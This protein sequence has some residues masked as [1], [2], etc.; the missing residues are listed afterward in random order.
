MATTQIEARG[1]FITALANRWWVPVVRGAA[2]LLFGIFT[3]FIP[4]A[5]LLALVLLWGS[6]AVVDG[7]FNLVLG[8]RRG[9]AGASWGWFFFEGLVS[10]AAGV[11]TFAWPGITALVL[12][13]VIAVWAVVTG[14]IEIGAAI[15]LRR[16]LAHEWLLALAGVLSIAFGIALFMRP[17]AGALAVTWVI[18]TYAVVFGVA[19]IAFGVRIYR[20]AHPHHGPMTTTPT[21]A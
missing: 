6:Y 5:S 1:P 12:L 10:I 11:L 15:E 16:V 21:A 7:V 3:F 14:I 19:L 9:R 2:A 18:G 4:G 13:Y 20:W 17:G 8:F